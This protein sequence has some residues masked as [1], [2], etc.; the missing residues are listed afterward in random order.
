[1][2][3]NRLHNPQPHPRSFQDATGPVAIRL[4]NDY[5]FKRILE[6]N[7]TVLRALIGSLLH[8]SIDEI[9]HLHILNPIM[10]GDAITD[11]SVILD[12]NVEINHGA[13]MDLEMQVVNYKD[14]PE[15]SLYYACR[16]YLN[17][18][19]S[20]DY[21]T[22]APSWQIGFVDYTIFE[23]HPSFYSTYKLTDTTDHYVYT[24]KFSIGVVDMSKIDLATKKDR[25]YNIDR[26]AKLFKAQTW[27]D[28]KMLAKQDVYISKAGETYFEISAD[29]HERQLAEAREDVLRRE[30]ATKRR[31]QE[32]LRSLDAAHNELEKKDQRIAEHEQRI[33]EKDQRI[34]EKDQRIAELEAL[35]ARK[36]LST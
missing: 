25:Q 19:R 14:W 26:W 15:R 20:Q 13:R 27:E 3:N 16:N 6:K 32:L 34:A 1:M 17:L 4:T 31:E 29:E 33:A 2:Q 7:E 22:V 21:D 18:T 11:R 9:T 30:R 5:I 23:D 12:V 35:L 36:N 8:R 28:I 24:D 10:P